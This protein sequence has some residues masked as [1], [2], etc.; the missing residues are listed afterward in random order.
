MSGV[1]IFDQ[2]ALVCIYNVDRRKSGI[3]AIA[4]AVK[5]ADLL[6]DRRNRLGTDSVV[7]FN[8]WLKVRDLST[9]WL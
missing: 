6:T 9:V 4:V 1:Q 5:F 7:C 2:D 3:R 8:S